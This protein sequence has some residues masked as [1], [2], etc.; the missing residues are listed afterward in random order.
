MP[1]ETINARKQLACVGAQAA[2]AIAA[3]HTSTTATSLFGTCRTSRHEESQEG[4]THMGTQTIYLVAV[5]FG[6]GEESYS[7][8]LD[9]YTEKRLA[10]RRA[11]EEN[12]RIM[13]YLTQREC[14]SDFMAYWESTGPMK[15]VDPDSD[16]YN[17][18]YTAEYN[19]LCDIICFTEDTAIPACAHDYFHAY[20]EE[21]KLFT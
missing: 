9:S 4:K 21:L 3:M 17:Q 16:T 12:V 15:G 8:S 13:R 20:V 6:K 11:R 19:R 14:V 1:R 18:A 2:Q 5:S 7:K 10:D